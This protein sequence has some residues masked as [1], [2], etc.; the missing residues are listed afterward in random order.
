M[1]AVGIDQVLHFVIREIEKGA[2]VSNAG[3]QD[4][5]GDV[6]AFKLL[7]YWQVGRYGV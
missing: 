3:I 4:Q 5:K 7:N 1:K 2:K 6:Q